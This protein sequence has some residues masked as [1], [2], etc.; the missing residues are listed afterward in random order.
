MSNLF[1]GPNPIVVDKEAGQTQGNSTISYKKE[2]PEELWEKKPGGGWSQVN[3]HVV[4]GLGDVAQL[5][6]SYAVTLKPGLLY[7]AGIFEEGHGPRTTDPIR[8]ASLKVFCLWKKPEVRDLITDQNRASGGTWHAHQVHT[9]VPTNLVTIAVSRIRPTLDDNGIP[10]LVSPEGAP[11][12]PLTTSNDHFVE[13]NPL[14]PGN[15]YFFVALVTDSF[16]NWDFRQEEF[17]TLRRRVIVEFPT[18]HIFNDGDP[19]D[20]GEGEFWFR[21]YNGSPPQ[22]RVIQD[23]HLPTQDIDDWGET[24]RPYAINLAHVGSLETISPSTWSVW[25]GSWGIEHDGIFEA[26]EGAHSRDTVLPFPAGRF[27]E[28]VTN[29]TFRMDCPTSTDADFH[30]GVDVRW[31]VDY[32]A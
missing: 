9:S 11:T 5:Q 22:P 20:D 30:Y 18:I 8:V 6:G 31:S 15:H 23:F 4:T 14:L 25:V 27:V 19:F 28:N 32:A 1:A 7:E 13:I 2:K 21:L 29:A 16:G 12:V 10:V 3:V 17:D 26:D 24:D